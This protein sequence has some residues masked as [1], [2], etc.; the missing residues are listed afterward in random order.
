MAVQAL[1][2]ALMCI[3][4]PFCP[5]ILWCDSVTVCS[6][7]GWTCLPQEISFFAMGH[8]AGNT[9][10]LMPHVPSRTSSPSAFS[11]RAQCLHAQA[12]NL[13][14]AFTNFRADLGAAASQLII[15]FDLNVGIKER[16]ECVPVC[17]NGEGSK[18]ERNSDLAG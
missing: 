16:R 4:Q 13:G 17:V 8:H 9:A 6:M 5:H 14:P 11:H 12:K 2:S 10:L 15:L 7:Q 1:I 3:S 18:R